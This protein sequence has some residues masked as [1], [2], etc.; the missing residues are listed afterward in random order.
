MNQNQTLLLS[1]FA[2]Q[3]QLTKKLE[4]RLSL[5][6]LSFTELQVMLHLAQAPQQSLRRIDL[7]ELAGL[8]A[9]G[10]TRLLLPM[11][12]LHLVEREANP[13][14]ARVSLVKLSEAGAER[15][16]EAMATFE[17]AA[18]ELLAPLAPAQQAQLQALT[19]RLLQGT[20]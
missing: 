2:L 3:G 6:G 8:S 14:D 13:R 19:E 17:L 18:D 16:T 4:R 20:N 15:L 9:S 12:K 11:E 5:H 7:A 1:L 10:V